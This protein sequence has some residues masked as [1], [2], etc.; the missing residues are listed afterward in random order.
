[1]GTHKE[2]KWEGKYPHVEAHANSDGTARVVLTFYRETPRGNT[3]EYEVGFDMEVEQLACVGST[4][5]RTVHHAKE[6]AEARIQAA[7]ERI[8]TPGK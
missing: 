1:M 2:F 5:R 3:E 6:R 4:F 7:Y 8:I